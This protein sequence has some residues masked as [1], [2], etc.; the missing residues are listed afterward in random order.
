MFVGKLTY[1]TKLLFES[2]K[3][4]ASVMEMLEW[5][6]LAVRECSSICFGLKKKS[7]VDLHARFYAKFRESQPQIPSQVVI[8]A[9]RECLARY[10]A[11][12]SNDHKNEKP[13]FKKGLN[14][15]LDKRLYSIRKDGR[16]S[17][18]GSNG[19]IK[20]S[21]SLYPK[22]AD[23]W[24]KYKI[25]DPNL[26]VRDGQIWISLIFDIPEIILPQTAATGFD[27]GC[28]NFAV[29]S[30]GQVYDDKK[31]KGEMRRLRFLKRQLR[32]KADKGS[33]SA[34]RHLKKLRRKER[35]KNKNFI[36][37]VSNKILSETKTNV[38]ALENLKGVKRKAHKKQNKSRISQVPL[39]EFV[40][41][42][43][44]KAPKYG[45]TVIKVD[46]RNTSKT[47]SMTGKMDGTR[48]GRR[49]YCK[50]GVVL[51]ADWNAAI[52]IA[53]RTKL[54]VSSKEPLDGSLDFT[55]RPP[56]TGHTLSPSG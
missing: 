20:C 29:S 5:Q 17:I 47:N 21:P 51:D 12:K 10:K 31:F 43:T 25:C 26:F 44:Y 13:H 1:N 56:S 55:G 45:K 24:G 41:V 15:Q 9:E 33:R 42:I 49:Y 48:K 39:Y 14:I 8:T 53:R 30:D 19:R 6:R 28:R 11:S 27:L 50:N 38:I 46:P 37:Q 35:N 32:S 22:L 18:I 23:L 34:R 4:R 3:D 2:E 16:F 7:I 40:R 54:P 52:N 36:H